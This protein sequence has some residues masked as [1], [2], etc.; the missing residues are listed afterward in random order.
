MP[1]FSR[2]EIRAA[3][4]RLE[5]P[6]RQPDELIHI[7]VHGR[8]IN[9]KNQS[10][11]WQQKAWGRYKR[12]WKDSVFN[13]LLATRTLFPSM[14]SATTPKTVAFICRTHGQMDD[15][16]LALACAPIRDAL[17]E[18]G[19]ISG[20]APRDGNSFVYSQRIDRTHRGVEI[21][22]KRAPQNAPQG[23]QEAPGSTIG[24][25]DVK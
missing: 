8:L 3:L 9:G 1:S 18:A 7:F 24:P 5:Q 23:P 4:D 16:G 17:T 11:G 2:A 21:V 15:D 12:D 20:D 19:V 13:V 10:Q 14:L 22:V 25:G 6:K